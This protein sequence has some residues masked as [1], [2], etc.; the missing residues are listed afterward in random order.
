MIKNLPYNLEFIS[1]IRQ[2]FLLFILFSLT[3][4]LISSI[5]VAKGEMESVEITNLSAV[6]NDKIYVEYELEGT[7]PVNFSGV[8]MPTPVNN[9]VYKSIGRFD[10]GILSQST[11]TRSKI[12]KPTNNADYY[13]IDI[14][15]QDNSSNRVSDKK[16]IDMIN[17][18]SID[19]NSID[20]TNKGSSRVCYE[21]SYFYDFETHND[22]SDNIHYEDSNN[23][24]N[25]GYN[26]GYR[27][28]FEWRIMVWVLT[29]AGTV[30]YLLFRFRS[31]I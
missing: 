13:I 28:I 27:E 8:I 21:N 25:D 12:I 30:F 31:L 17:S 1:M 24:Y 10:C 26:N 19:S 18:T 15:I 4:F 22:D 20:N 7:P 29:L 2:L 11:E 14:S 23:V 5:S 3:P 16:T 6:D 9:S